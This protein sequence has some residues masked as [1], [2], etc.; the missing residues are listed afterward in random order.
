MSFEKVVID[1]NILMLD[2]VSTA[3]SKILYNF[4]P[5]F[6]AAVID[7]LIGAGTTDIV[8]S[9]P[10]EFG[11]SLTDGFGCVNAVAEGAADI[12][13]GCDIN[14][15]L[16]KEASNKGIFFIKP[17]YG[18]VSRFGLV[19][20]A[21]SMEQIGIACKDIAAGFTALSMI[22][23]PDDRDGALA[24]ALDHCFSAPEEGLSG[25]KIAVPADD[26]GGLK[27]ISEKLAA[28]G[29]RVEPVESG[30]ADFDSVPA[31]AYAISAAETSNSISRFD[32]I[33][34][35]YRTG[36]YSHLEDIYL[37]SRTECFTFETKLF[38]LMG[39]LVLTKEHYDRYF[40]AALRRRR[41]IKNEAEK[42]LSAY[43]AI[44]TTAGSG[45]AEDGF[46]G[47]RESYENL[48][49]LA[50]PNLTG[51]PAAAFPGGVQFIAK[52][53]GE[54]TLLRIGKC[55]GRGGDAK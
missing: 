51:M 40:N 11:I 25:L 7:R 47:F 35:G 20:T 48:K 34:F 14:G 30:E 52:Q 33:K 12:G 45:Q 46:N 54:S 8:Q 28:L 21:P 36:D 32:G 10:N 1:D 31:V 38:T 55:L 13:L 2:R 50:L 15:S 23:G 17:T 37:K 27:G 39:M 43:D 41:R 6:N 22:A 19:S 4:T 18:T 24:E 42:I 16:R 44:M 26:S 29:A 5:P 53:F 9:R 3:G 49:Y